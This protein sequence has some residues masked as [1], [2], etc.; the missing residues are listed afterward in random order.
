MANILLVDDEA[1]ARGTMRSSCGSAATRCEDYVFRPTSVAERA[2]TQL[3]LRVTSRSST[4]HNF[5][6]PAQRIDRDIAPGETVE[7]ELAV[8]AGGACPSSANST[9]RSGNGAS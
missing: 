6:L 8:P 7:I 5:T 2:G 1:S 9:W 3:R 4:L